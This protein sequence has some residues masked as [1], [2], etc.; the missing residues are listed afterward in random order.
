MDWIRKDFSMHE[1]DVRIFN[2][3][4]WQSQSHVIKILLK[5]GSPKV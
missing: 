2:Y 1:R 5:N 4:E 3:D